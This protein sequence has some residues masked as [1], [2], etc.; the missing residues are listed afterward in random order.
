MPDPVHH[1]GR[2]ATLSTPSSRSPKILYRQAISSSEKVC[3]SSGV[4]STRPRRTVSI[5]LL[6]QALREGAQPQAQDDSGLNRSRIGGLQKTGGFLTFFTQTLHEF[7]PPA[8][9]LPRRIWRLI[10]FLDDNY[11]WLMR[12]FRVHA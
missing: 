10:R 11:T 8:L 12:A 5:S 9:V 2:I 3:V 4:R 1:H 6:V 7:F